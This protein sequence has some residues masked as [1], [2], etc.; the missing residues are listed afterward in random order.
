MAAHPTLSEETSSRFAP[1]VL[2][3]ERIC[4]VIVLLMGARCAFAG[5]NLPVG[6]DG[7]AY[8]DVARSYL[9]HDWHMAVNGYWG[10]LYSWLL[11]IGMRFFH[12][13]IRTEF[14]MARTLNF[15]IFT[16]AVYTFSRFWR[17]LAD[18]S[19]RISGDENSIPYAS[20]LVWIGLGYLLFVVNFIWNVDEVTPDI[21]VATIVFAIAAVLFKLNFKLNDNQHNIAAYVWLG[22]LLALAGCGKTRCE[23]DAVPRNSLV[24]TAQPDKKKACAEKTSNSWTCLAT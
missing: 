8:L 16:A 3:F 4:Q 6:A 12:P 7:L 21:L 24:S 20:P 1:N 10:P 17:G 2:G 5:R 23:A 9:R 18:W 19:K 14:A 15:A 22:L 13:G 11:A